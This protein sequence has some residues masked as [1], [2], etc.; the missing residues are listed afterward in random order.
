MGNEKIYRTIWPTTRD[1]SEQEIRGSYSDAVANSE[2]EDVGPVDTQALRVIME[3][4]DNN[5]GLVTFTKQSYDN[6][7]PAA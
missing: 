6:A 1:V 2:C 3:E 4:I 7:T 5:A